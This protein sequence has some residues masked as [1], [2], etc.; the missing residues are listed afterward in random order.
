M[1]RSS[2]SRRKR[3]SSSGRLKQ[4]TTKRVRGSRHPPGGRAEVFCV[5]L[6][7]LVSAVVGAQP[8][9]AGCGQSCRNASPVSASPSILRKRRGWRASG[10]PAAP[11]RQGPGDMCLVRHLA[12]PGAAQGYAKR[13]GA[14]LVSPWRPLLAPEAP[15]AFRAHVRGCGEGAGEPVPVPGRRRPPASAPTSLP[16]PGA[17]DAQRLA[18]E[19]RITGNCT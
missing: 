10:R 14:G 6:P 18:L 7:R 11:N 5:A 12:G 1:P 17:A 16:L 9:L 3:V 4:E 13:G 15:E 8:R 19:S 2:P